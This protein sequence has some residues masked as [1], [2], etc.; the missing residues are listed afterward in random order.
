MNS[1]IAAVGIIASLLFADAGMRPLDDDPVERVERGLLLIKTDPS[2]C[3]IKVDGVSVGQT[4]RLITDLPVT[5]VYSVTLSKAGFLD[6][7]IQVKFDGR[8]PV[9]K[10]ERMV[11]DSGSLKITSSPEGAEVTVNGIVRGRTPLTVEGIARGSADVRLSLD[12]FT[13]ETRKPVMRAGETQE[14]KVALTPKAGTVFLLSV[15]DG[16]L[17]HVNGEVR[18]RSPLV[19]SDMNPGV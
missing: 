6:R 19:I 9:V 14:V 15:P 18:G 10:E 11:S 16:G 4:P 17:F 12:G 5:A 7:T 13:P 3:D 2:G 8:T 1:V